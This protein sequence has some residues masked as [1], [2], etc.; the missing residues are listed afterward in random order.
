MKHVCLRVLLFAFLALPLACGPV[1]DL[2]DAGW[3]YDG[4]SQDAGDNCAVVCEISADCC[5]NQECNGGVCTAPTPCPS[6]CHGECDAGQSCNRTTLLCENQPISGTCI[7]DCD[8][9]ADQTCLDGLCVAVCVV[10]EDCPSGQICDRGACSTDV[11]CVSREDCAGG[12]CLVCRD[13]E[14][15]VPAAVCLNDE[16]CCVGM[17]CNFGSCVIDITPCENDEDCTNPELPLCLDGKC[18]AEGTQCLVDGDCPSENQVCE[19][20]L[21]VTTGCVATGCRLGE[22]CDEVSGLCK[23]GCD[24]NDDCAEPAICDYASHQ[25]LEMDCCGGLCNPVTE[26]C[27]PVACQ[28]FTP[29]TEGSCPPDSHCNLGTGRCEPDAFDCNVD[30]CGVDYVCNTETG[31]CEPEAF[32]CRVDGCG[33]GYECDELSGQ[34]VVLQAECEAADFS[35]PIVC[36]GFASGA[37]EAGCESTQRVGNYAKQFTFTGTAGHQ[38]TIDLISETDTYLYLLDAAG[39]VVDSDD[40]GGA[41]LDSKIVTILPADGDYTIEATT[42]LAAVTGPFDLQL[43]CEEGASCTSGIDCGQV[44]NGS[45]TGQ[46]EAPDWAGSYGRLYTFEAVEDQDI[47]IS[48]SSATVDTYLILLGPDGDVQAYNDDAGLF[49]TNSYLAGSILVGGTWTIEATTYDYDVTGDFVLEFVC[50]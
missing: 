10:D 34:C 3:V 7:D 11:G 45:W 32:D 39:A 21:C 5:E 47:E 46:C 13:G 2:P 6:G 49:D 23:P 48:L 24:S 29:C 12:E 42:Y 9:Y 37:F 16:D 31:Q 33:A 30:G 40:D 19:E 22:Y 14:C 1:D 43:S 41:S 15:V 26:L 17:H 38:V 18:A 28:C 27:D 4:A 25:C 35:S 36:G 44:V 50:P 8:C 20:G